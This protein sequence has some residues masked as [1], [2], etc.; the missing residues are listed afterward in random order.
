[1]P[2]PAVL[3]AL[4]PP[5]PQDECP[6]PSWPGPAPAQLLGIIAAWLTGEPRLSRTRIWERLVDE[7]DAEFTCAYLNAYL[8]RHRA[9]F[10]G[11]AAPETGPP[12]DP[13]P[14]PG[15]QPLPNEKAR[16]GPQ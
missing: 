8:N 16:P 12:P 13:Q 6:S 11:T 1:M 7:H 10:N 15:Q 14:H 5:A 2:R 9:R 4:T 3:R